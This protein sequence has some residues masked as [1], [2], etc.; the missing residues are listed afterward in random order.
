MNK[1]YVVYEAYVIISLNTLKPSQMVGILQTTIQTDFRGLK[2]L[3]LDS[4]FTDIHPS[5]KVMAVFFQ[6]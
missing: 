6:T 2:L 3:H 4:N 5:P 1:V